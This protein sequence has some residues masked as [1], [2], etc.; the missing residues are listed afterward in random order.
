MIYELGTSSADAVTIRPEY[1]FKNAIKQQRDEHRTKAGNLYLY[2]WSEHRHI[3][4]PV[5]YVSQANASQIESWWSANTKLLFFVTSGS[6]TD[7][8]S[9]MILNND[10]PLQQYNKPY[11]NML[12]GKIILEQY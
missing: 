9:V 11:D 6:T 2:K 3:E 1:S 5:E 10:S 7:V 4:I 8:Y 12:R